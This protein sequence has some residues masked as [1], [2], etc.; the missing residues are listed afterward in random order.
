MRNDFFFCSLFENELEYVD[1]LISQD[2]RNNSAWNQRF[3]VLQH[4][5]LT[6]EV[7]QHE[8]T[9]VMNR[10]AYVKN[11]ESSWNFLRGLLNH[12]GD[13]TLTQYPEVLTFCERLYEQGIRAPFLLGFLMEL[14]EEHYFVE[15]SDQEKQQL[16]AKFHELGRL[17]EEQYDKI[18]C[19]YW[20]YVVKKFE[21]RKEKQA[22]NG[23]KK[24]LEEDES[25]D[26]ELGTSEETPF[27]A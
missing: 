17:L 19:K 10:I 2:V 14:Y 25:A 13:K 27:T 21:V 18:R 22:I 15:A 7:M 4:M 1:R 8:I 20:G 9:Y 23:D 24:R 26:V 3:F 6:P 11:N 12:G 5:G 16:D